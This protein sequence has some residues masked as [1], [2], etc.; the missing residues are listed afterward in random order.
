MNAFGAQNL[1]QLSACWP[2]VPGQ[3]P[4]FKKTIRICVCV[5]TKFASS[6][7]LCTIAS[8]AASLGASDSLLTPEKPCSSAWV[9]QQVTVLALHL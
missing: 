3:C 7:A 2:S 1:P 8:S 5:S 4:R 6:E 9:W